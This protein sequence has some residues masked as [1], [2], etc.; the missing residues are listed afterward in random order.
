MDHEHRHLDLGHL[1]HRIELLRQEKT[2]GQPRVTE[3][4]GDVGKRGECRLDDEAS[5]RRGLATRS[6]GWRR[7]L[8]TRTVARRVRQRT[9]DVPAQ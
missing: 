7:D 9:I 1:A 6:V 3:F 2:D 4:F 8:A 5:R